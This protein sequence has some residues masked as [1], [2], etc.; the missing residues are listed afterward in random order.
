[1]QNL[2]TNKKIV[3]IIEDKKNVNNNS[4]SIGKI[5]PRSQTLMPRGSPNKNKPLSNFNNINNASTSDKSKTSISNSNIPSPSEFKITINN[6]SNDYNETGSN[7]NFLSFASNTK[8]PSYNEVSNYRRRTYSNK[9][10]LFMNNLK[11]KTRSLNHIQ[12]LDDN[13]SHVQLIIDQ[14]LD[15]QDK[16][17]KEKLNKKLRVSYS[18]KRTFRKSSINSLNNHPIRLSIPFNSNKNENINTFLNTNPQHK[19]YIVNS[20]DKINPIIQDFIKNYKDHYFSQFL[21]KSIETTKNL[22]HQ[23]FYKKWD[24]YI[25]YEDKIK[26]FEFKILQEDGKIIY[27]LNFLY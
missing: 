18:N 11:A 27:L 16:S 25:R 6:I 19:N 26:D 17:F 24:N 1:L 2:L 9:L 8:S 7:S 3:K 4:A 22:N 23:I 5:K 12:I 14:D 10:T 21:E 15:N 20:N 13:F